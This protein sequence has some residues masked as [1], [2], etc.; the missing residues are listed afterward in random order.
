MPYKDLLFAVLTYPDTTPEAAL[1]GGAGLARRLGG[2]A[3][4]LVLHVDIPTLHNRLANLVGGFNKL[5]AEEE[6]RSAARA[7]EA[8]AAFAR[9]GAEV[10]LTVHTEIEKAPLYEEGERVCAHARTRD[11]TLMPIGPAVLEDRGIAEAV[12]FGSGRPLVV[13][14]E[15]GCCGEE[16]ESFKAAAIAWDGSARAARAVADALPALKRAGEVRILAVTGE[17]PSVRAGGTA[18]LV[19]H[20][21]THGIEAVVDEIDARGAPIGR[22]VG[23]YVGERWIELL[24]MG[25]F[26]HSRA[27]EF[28]LGGAT[29]A[30]LD[31]PPCAVLLS[32]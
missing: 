1:R 12:L 24:V 19:R 22:V 17:K 6:A 2:E 14:P 26:G 15:A 27:R 21:K 18:D 3:A 32:H 5:A 20:L 28:V 8:A 9:A 13:F 25:G 23:D 31:A 16:G 11:L 30:M 4:A 10:G 29:A 7:Q